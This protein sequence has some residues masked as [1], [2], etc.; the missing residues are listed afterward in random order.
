MFSRN[1]RY[2]LRQ[3]VRNRLFAVVAVLTLALGIGMT[4]SMFSIVYAVLM[5]PLPFTDAE[6]IALI[7]QASPDNQPGVSS[8]PDLRDWREQS[9]TFK[10]IAYWELAVLNLEN[11]GQMRSVPAI[12][13]SANL[14]SLLGAQAMLGRTIFPNE[15]KP[16]NTVAV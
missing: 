12:R 6:Q 1:L 3:L 8:L 4:A 10:D 16:E 14:F 5:R 7:G 11:G 13:C 2:G 15:D 9:K